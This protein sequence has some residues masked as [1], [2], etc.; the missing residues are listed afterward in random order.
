MYTNHV[1]K[2]IEDMHL[3]ER[4]AYGYKKVIILMMI[5]DLLSI[6]VICMLFA[7]LVNYVDKLMPRI[8]QSKCAGSM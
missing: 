5:S 4:I 8:S 2:K 6:M 1:K 3:Q 7:N